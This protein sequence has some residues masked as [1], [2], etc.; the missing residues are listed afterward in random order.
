MFDDAPFYT[1][2][3]EAKGES[4]DFKEF[5]RTAKDP[6]DIWFRLVQVL[7]SYEKNL[8][9]ELRSLESHLNRMK[10]RQQWLKHANLI[11]QNRAGRYD[12]RPDYP[13][14]RAEL[15]AE[16]ARVRAPHGSP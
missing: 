2:Q 13:R 15:D 5:L 3:I 10:M 6:D 8:P 14:V 9:A 1:M 12:D 11:L 7:I 16:L 4:D